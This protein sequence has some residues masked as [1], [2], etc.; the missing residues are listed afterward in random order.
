MKDYEIKLE[1][2]F[3]GVRLS[4][5]VKKELITSGKVEVF[6]DYITCTGMMISF[7]NQ[8]VTCKINENSKY[9]VDFVNN[10]ICLKKDN[11]IIKKIIIIEPAKYMINN[12]LNRNGQP[13]SDYVVVHKYRARIQPIS[14]CAYDCKF[15][16][17]NLYKYQKYPIELLDDALQKAIKENEIKNLLISAGTPKKIN[18]DYEYQNDVYK[19]FCKKY[20]SLPIDIMTAPRGIDINKNKESHIEFFKMLKLLNIAD[21]SVNLE[22]YNEEAR[23]KYIPLKNYYTRKEYLDYMQLA[24]EYLENNIVKSGIIVGLENED[25]TL[26]A[27]EE[28]AKRKIRVIL[29]PYIPFNNIGKSPTPEVMKRILLRAKEITNKY[30]STLSSKYIWCRH[31]E[32]SF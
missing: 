20:D 17:D 31:N 2:L 32:I 13:Y 5:I 21:L 1:L 22:L 7:N 4:N 29:S 24:T 9:I 6:N 26:K 12:E 16:N 15:C 3:Y 18:S 23:R 10:Q 30:D 19:Y 14:G 27:I 11:N 8:Y 25:D 28:L